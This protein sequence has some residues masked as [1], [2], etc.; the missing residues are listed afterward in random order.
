MWKGYLMHWLSI[1][2]IFMIIAGT[3]CTYFG[4]ELRQRQDMFA[5]R[6][7]TPDAPMVDVAELRAE[8]ANQQTQ[9][10]HIQKENE[11]LR[12]DNVTLALRQKRAEEDAEVYKFR[13]M[14]FQRELSELRKQETGATA[15]TAAP[16]PPPVAAATPPPP[17]AAGWPDQG[18]E[19]EN[20]LDIIDRLQSLLAA[21]D[22]AALE[23]SAAE[24]TRNNPGWMTP[25]VYLGV[26]NRH[27]GRRQQALQAFI[28]VVENG[29]GDPAYPRA[30]RALKL[31]TTGIQDLAEQNEWDKLIEACEKSIGKDPEW[32][33][34]Y[35]FAGLA[36]SHRGERQQATEFLTTFI[37]NTE[38]DPELGRAQ[39]ALRL[40]QTNILDLQKQGD[41]P[42][43][44]RACERELE[45]DPEWLTP[46][47]ILGLSY[48]RLGNTPKARENLEIF[49]QRGADDPD[50]ENAQRLLDSLE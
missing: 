35:Y 1:L 27:L 9:L 18:H 30:E 39:R 44:I 15:E 16:T 45:N 7:Q 38:N 48:A 8:Y 33:L 14:E 50:Y 2:G 32:Y 25:Y 46:Y 43:L 47:Y 11:R 41:Y 12:A 20:E 10:N 36:Y 13:S 26:A 40:L 24:Q 4:V 23:R 42:A 22:Y 28:H 6:D 29:A 19:E 34:P 5:P 21:R 31:M 17:I 49:I 37:R 3:A